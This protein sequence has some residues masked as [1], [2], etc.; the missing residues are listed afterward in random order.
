[1]M[2]KCPNCPLYRRCFSC[3]KKKAEELK[4]FKRKKAKEFQD[5]IE[6]TNP[7]KVFEAMTRA[8]WS[9]R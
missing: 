9:I 8:E 3:A 4:T 7:L 6:Y 5:S 1:M 2:N